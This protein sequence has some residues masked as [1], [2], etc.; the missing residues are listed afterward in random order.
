MT[1]I[2]VFIIDR[3]IAENRVRLIA[4]LDWIHKKELQVN[5]KREA[6]FFN[7]RK[8]FLSGI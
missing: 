3:A 4:I 1:P 7:S 6:F 5:V 2:K 8:Y